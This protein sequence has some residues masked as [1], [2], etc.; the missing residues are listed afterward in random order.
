MEFAGG[1]VWARGW[2]HGA[3]H[4]LSL[5]LFL[6]F[7]ASREVVFIWAFAFLRYHGVQGWGQTDL[8]IHHVGAGCFALNCFA[9]GG[10]QKM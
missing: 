6:F 9:P 1:G 2:V 10:R 4:E 5:A 7:F 3:E 8:V